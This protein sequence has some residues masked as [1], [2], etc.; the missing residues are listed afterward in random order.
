MS[1]QRNTPKYIQF[2]S[3]HPA[4]V[5]DY[6]LDMFSAG[7]F[8]V[9]NCSK[10]GETE[11][12]PI[13]VYR[14]DPKFKKFQN[15][16]KKSDDHILVSY[17]EYYN[18]NWIY[19]YTNYGGEFTIKVYNNKFSDNLKDKYNPRNW[20]SYSGVRV[21]A[22]TFDEMIEGLYYEVL[23]N[24]GDFQL[25]DNKLLTEAEILNHK[26]VKHYIKE[27]VADRK[28]GNAYHLIK[29][30]DYFDVTNPIYNRRWLKWFAGS[31]YYQEHFAGEFDTLIEK[32]PK[33]VWDLSKKRKP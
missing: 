15:R 12:D 17:K 23:D 8:W 22:K 30:K 31:I 18:K 11:L 2:L 4:I 25:G 6:C 5:A 14:N 27:P 19:D 28:F 9:Y 32:T 13:Y 10:E 20:M 21:K 29:N 7:C 3:N 16:F 1:D 33:W 26:T 24:F